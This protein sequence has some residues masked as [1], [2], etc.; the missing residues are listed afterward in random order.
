MME[1]DGV[2]IDQFESFNQQWRTDYAVEAVKEFK[3]DVLLLDYYIPPITGLKVLRALNEA[4]ANNEIDRP[5]FIIGMSSVASCN[6]EMLKEGADFA[7]VKHEMTSWNAWP[8]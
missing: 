6:N 8:R 7:F 1:M 3:P 2:K 4:I 5:R